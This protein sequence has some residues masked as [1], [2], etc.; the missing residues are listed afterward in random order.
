[1]WCHFLWFNTDAGLRSIPLLR[2]SH[3]SGELGKRTR[4]S[5]DTPQFT[6][7]HPPCPPPP[8][9]TGRH[10]LRVL[11]PAVCI[12]AV[13]AGT[14]MAS[15]GPTPLQEAGRT[16]TSLPGPPSETSLRENVPKVVWLDGGWT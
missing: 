9:E 12:R 2:S 13:T 8:R 15:V 6:S 14:R 4:Y 16:M 7:R 5:E 10:R 11:S 1:M 3:Y